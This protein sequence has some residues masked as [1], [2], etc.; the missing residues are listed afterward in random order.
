MQPGTK[1]LVQNNI[2]KDPKKIPFFCKQFK[3]KR[4]HSTFPFPPHI[5][6]NEELMVRGV[7]ILG[8]PQ[9]KEQQQQNNRHNNTSTGVGTST[10]MNFN[11]EDEDE[12]LDENFY[13]RF[14]PKEL[15]FQ[16]TDCCQCIRDVN[17]LR[18]ELQIEKMLHAEQ[19][20][21]HGSSL[22]P[23]IPPPPSSTLSSNYEPDIRKIIHVTVNSKKKRFDCFRGGKGF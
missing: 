17:I 21:H 7:E 10:T 12:E 19:Q 23:L 16:L 20:R 6:M 9:Q 8:D 11:E 18:K 5:K 13:M 14:I 22:K 4:D 3:Q 1:T 15:Q 2:K